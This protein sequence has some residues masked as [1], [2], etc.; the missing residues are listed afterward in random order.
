MLH[1][2]MCV[3]AHCAHPVHLGLLLFT[4]TPV[5]GTTRVELHAYTLDLS[6]QGS[7]GASSDSTIRL[8]DLYDRGPP[9]DEEGGCRGRTKMQKEEG[10]RREEEG[11]GIK[12]DDDGRG[13]R[14][15]KA[16]EEG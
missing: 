6:G 7:L 15:T 5:S 1:L 14:K 2:W 16:Q 10:M 8:G 4:F 13:R 3:I 11:G 12:R 9:K